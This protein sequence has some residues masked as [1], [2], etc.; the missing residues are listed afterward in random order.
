[1]KFSIILSE[2]NKQLQEVSSIAGASPGKDDITQNI[3]ISVHNNLL[4][5]KATD[6]V[7][8]LIANIPLTDVSSEGEIIMNASKLREALKNLDPKTSICFEL[9]ESN[10]KMILTA[11]STTFEIRTRSAADFPKFEDEDSVQDIVLSKIS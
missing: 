2:L 11:D 4:Q 10:Q 7:I 1:M 5:L 6:Y 9:D 8:E 3:Y